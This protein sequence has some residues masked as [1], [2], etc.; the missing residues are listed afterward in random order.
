MS[1]NNSWVF[2]EFSHN[3]K[4][5]KYG[6]KNPINK[7][8]KY[9]VNKMPNLKETA[10]AYEPPKTKNIADLKLVMVDEEIVTKEFQDKEGK[11][12]SVNVIT[13]DGE[14][15]RVPTSVLKQLKVIIE[16]KPGMASFKVKRTGT[17]IN[18]T[19]YTVIP[20]D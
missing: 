16:E 3:K 5:N 7:K 13:I 11:T 4:L 20:L 12:F 1:V 8:Q 2:T 15:Y 18:D 9:E 14:D 17:T 19:V 6:F 10:E